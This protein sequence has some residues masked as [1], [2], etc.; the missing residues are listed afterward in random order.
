[1]SETSYET[2]LLERDPKG[3]LEIRLNRPEKHN[4]FNAT[5]IEELKRAFEEASEEE[6]VRVVLLTGSGK[7]F[8]AGADIDWM[9]DQG[10][11]S[12][13]ANVQSALRMSEMFYAVYACKK[14]VLAKVGGAALG[15]GTGLV[16]AVDIAI[17]SQDAIFGF[18]EVRLGIIPAVISPF[19]VEKLGPATARS[20][21]LLGKRFNGIEAERLGLVFRS[22]PAAELDAEV[23]NCLADLLR[24][25]PKALEEAKALAQ[26]LN[27]IPPLRE[28]PRCAEA[29]AKIRG[30]PE[31][32]EGLS[33]FLERRRPSWF[34]ENK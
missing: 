30:T 21:F 28:I 34:P 8:S 29:I 16:A 32:Q 27:P 20:L 33:A 19:A 22:V 31:A 1:M 24:G 15:G 17:A 13:A 5:V 4:A 3:V 9:R 6:G 11:E 12:E 18:T 25:S 7:S 14:P 23:E 26:S 10:R 2:L